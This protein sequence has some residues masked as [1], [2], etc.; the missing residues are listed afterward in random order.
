MTETV[1]SATEEVGDKMKFCEVNTDKEA[2]IVQS[3]NVRTI[4]TLHFVKNGTSV[5]QLRGVV[6]KLDLLGKIS[7]VLTEHSAE[8]KDKPS[9]DNAGAPEASTEEKTE[10]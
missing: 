6:S 9:S 7:G 10:E 5:D 2:R 3:L 1:K 8:A 4:P